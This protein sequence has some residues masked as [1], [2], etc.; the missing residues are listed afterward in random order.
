[1]QASS[2]LKK[3][4]KC[5]LAS[6]RGMW[7]WIIGLWTYKWAKPPGRDASRRSPF[8]CSFFAFKFLSGTT[9]LSSLVL[10][11]IFCLLSSLLV[12]Y[13][14]LNVVSEIQ[15]IMSRT[16]SNVFKSLHSIHVLVSQGANTPSSTAWRRRSLLCLCCKQTIGCIP[17]IYT[18]DSMR[19]LRYL[20]E[21]TSLLELNQLIIMW[22]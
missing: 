14:M 8:G 19:L 1:M 22:I 11:S 10:L 2:A 6:L 16:R 4:S 13:S 15:C 7:L 5:I 20:F 18:P 9:W 3:D 21:K 17:S 12:K